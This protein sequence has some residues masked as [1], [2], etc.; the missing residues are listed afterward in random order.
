L[1]GLDFTSNA[2]LMKM[3]S[4]Q[5]NRLFERILFDQPSKIAY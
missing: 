2:I 5:K 4:A 1:C 3:K